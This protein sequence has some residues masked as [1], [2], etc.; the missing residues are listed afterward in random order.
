MHAS[1]TM[2]QQKGHSGAVGSRASGQIAVAMILSLACSVQ[3]R[4]QN[5]VPNGSFEDYYDCPASF[6]FWSEVVGWTSPY[7]QSAD[8]FNRC[9]TGVVCSVP[10]NNMGFQEPAEGDAYMGIATFVNDG[11]NYRE[12]IA[13]ELAEPLEVGVPTYLSFKCSP[14]GFGSWVGNSARWK[15]KGPGMQFFRTLPSN[16]QAYLYPNAAALEMTTTLSDTSTWVTISGTYIPD[17]AYSWLVITNFYENTLSLPV[18][19]DSLGIWDVAYAFVDD[20]CVSY[21]PNY[22]SAWTGIPSPLDEW[23]VSVQNPFSDVLELHNSTSMTYPEP[24]HLFDMLG[25]TVWRGVW[26]QGER[27]W[28]V[29]MPELEQGVFLL[30]STDPQSRFKT[31]RVFHVSP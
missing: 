25:R 6:G 5:L 26:P 21:D 24:L 3:A 12:V 30:A 28:T 13:T 20:V 8:Y 10:F 4:G 19:M 17:S 18:F 7:T 11:P 9:A 2:L 31:I 15:A 29:P 23:A 27:S 16:W 1:S 14:G 22:C